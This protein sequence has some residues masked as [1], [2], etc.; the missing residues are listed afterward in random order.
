MRWMYAKQRPEDNIL[1]GYRTADEARRELI[2][3]WNVFAFFAK[4]ASLSDWSPNGQPAPGATDVLDRW[5]LSRTASAAA[6]VG[7]DLADYDARAAALRIGEHI[8]ELS[9]WYLR[10]SRRRL[11][12]SDD[13]ADRDQAFGVL[14]SAL[15]GLTRIMAPV[16]PFLAEGLYQRLVA[17]ADS[18]H[19][20]A[21]PEGEM[22]P[23]R[24]SGIEAAMTT[25]RRAVELM[26]T[27]RGQAG[28][29]LRQPLARMWLALPGGSL[30]VADAAV[31]RALLELLREEVNVKS[32]ELIGDDSTLV[33]RRVKPLL[34]R[35]GP[36]L[37]TQIPTVMAA[38]RANEVEYLPGG[39]VRLGG[40]ELAADEVEILATPREGTAVAHDEGLVVIAETELTDE[41]RAEGDARELTR[42]VQD[43]RKQAGLEFDE[44]IDLWLAAPA[45]V[46]SPLQ[47]YLAA[48]ADDTIAE[49]VTHDSPPADAVQA[50]Q[51]VSGG[52]VVIGLRGR[53]S[54]G[55]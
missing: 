38:A 25:V 53:G 32:L 54:A 35:I 5:I 19:L 20:T 40:V 11:S 55:R 3:L 18:V 22:A 34:P 13:E 29:R 6:D 16:L 7:A 26:R 37:G 48:L 8:D 9:T 49:S 43:L 21:W 42:A 39:G 1:F 41:L 30:G 28:I 10:R 45:D 31:E 14:H 17:D 46:L 33:E 12:R 44:P 4:Y 27:L 23:W 52:E 47:P 15:V 2:V 50:R 36:R 24:D 51:Q